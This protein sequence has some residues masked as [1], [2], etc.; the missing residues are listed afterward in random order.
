MEE[1]IELVTKMF[2]V[3]A[4]KAKAAVS[5]ALGFLRSKMPDAASGQFDSAVQSLGLQ[6]SL[7]EV[8]D[9]DAVAKRAGIAK[10]KVGSLL[11]IVLAFLKE[12]LPGGLG[13][14]EEQLKG[15]G[16]GGLLQKI[17]ALFGKS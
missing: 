8:A 17:G 5:A 12:K 2:G 13:G 16:A 4:D 7:P 15:A 1:L 11:E 9:E 3:S 6:D 14:L 10:D